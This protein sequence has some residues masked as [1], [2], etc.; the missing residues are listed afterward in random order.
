MSARKLQNSKTIL[1]VDDDAIITKSLLTELSSKGYR[2]TIARD[3]PEAV[4]YLR[5]QRP[6]LIL[7]DLLLPGNVLQSSLVWDG[8]LFLAW[9]NCLA[10]V[11]D[12]PVIVTTGVE[13]EKCRDLCLA[14]G[15]CAFF[16]KPLDHKGLLKTVQEKLNGHIQKD[17]AVN[18]G[19]ILKSKQSPKRRHGL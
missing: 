4:D 14:S 10:R 16:S 17:Q 5:F 13:P 15:A 3:G 18:A 7:L 9:L 19:R 2:V 1:L 8:F 6:D 11:G 12:I